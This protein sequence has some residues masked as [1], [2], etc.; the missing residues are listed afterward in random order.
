M[1]PTEEQYL[2]VNAL[3]TLALLEWRLYDEDTG[4]WRI[5]TTSPVLPVAYILPNGEI[6][7]PEW[8]LDL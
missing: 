4:L 2:I 3:E 6:I 5:Q 7:P 1:E 8:V